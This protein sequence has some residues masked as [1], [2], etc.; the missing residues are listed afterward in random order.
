MKILKIKK[1]NLRSFTTLLQVVLFDV[2][3]GIHEPSG[4]IVFTLVR[5]SGGI[6]IVPL[7]LDGSHFSLRGRELFF[8]LSDPDVRSKEFNTINSLS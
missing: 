8:G 1:Y 7:C 6:T 3:I 5:T 2:T 4:K